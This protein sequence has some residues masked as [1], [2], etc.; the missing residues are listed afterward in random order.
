MKSKLQPYLS[1]NK[2]TSDSRFQRRFKTSTIGECKQIIQQNRIVDPLN[3]LN[4]ETVVISIDLEVPNKK[5]NVI[6]SGQLY[7]DN[8]MPD[9]CVV[10]SFR[11][12]KTIEG[13]LIGSQVI[14]C[15]SL[16]YGGIGFA[17]FHQE[18]FLDETKSGH[19]SYCLTVK[20]VNTQL[21]TLTPVSVINRYIYV[22]LSS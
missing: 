20:C 14:G 22:Q 12:G 10:I 11:K 4:E 2:R 7:T 6:L 13:E 8:I 17:G 21:D 19:L 15:N 1:D 16:P 5:Y 3:T 18:F 9:H